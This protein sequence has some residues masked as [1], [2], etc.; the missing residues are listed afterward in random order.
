LG[1]ACSTG[2]FSITA[3][4]QPSTAAS[5]TVSGVKVD[6]SAFTVRTGNIYCVAT[7]GNDANSGKF[8]NCW[9]TIG[10]AAEG[11]GS[12]AAGD[13][14]Y[15]ENG[16][17]LSPGGGPYSDTL[18]IGAPG[19]AANPIA[20]IA[21]PGATV[22]IGTPTGD[23]RGI[24]ACNGLSGCSNGQDWV[25]AG[26]T[27][28]AISE[29]LQLNTVGFRLVANDVSCPNGN[30]Q[31]GCITGGPPSSFYYGNAVH[32]VA[33]N[34]ASSVTRLY[35]SI[36]LGDGAHAVDLG[37]NSITHNHGN[38]AIQIFTSTSGGSGDIYD[39]H[40][41]D[42]LIHDSRGIGI[43]MTSVA[44]QK[45]PLEAYNNLIYNA[46]TGP[47][48]ADGPASVYCFESTLGTGA[49]GTLQLYN[50]TFYNCGWTGGAASNAAAI[51]AFAPTNI[52][53]NLIYNP[54]P[55]MYFDSG[56]SGMTCANNLYFGS[57]AAPS[58]CAN[59]AVSADPKITSLSTFDFHLQ[60]GSPAIDKGVA[61]A[62]LILDL[63]GTSRPQGAAYDIG[64]YE[65]NQGSTPPPPPPP[66]TSACDLNS[67]NSVNVADVQVCVNQVLGVVPCT[68]A[69]L[70]G[71]G[72][73]TAVDVQRV[74][75][76]V[77]GQT[78][79]VGQ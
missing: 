14:I 41:H 30:D 17:V 39:I 61:I 56:S 68:N 76:S 23:Q 24:Y 70:Q 40:A 28:R 73:C 1:S 58:S 18:T 69:D 5:V 19:T 46:G 36:Y 16:V 51:A 59:G 34:S 35:H 55:L 49:S 79:V 29:G 67:D 37:W 6:N 4:G 25:F 45:G 50:N 10:H 26:L 78:C 52:R 3:N 13:I 57:G 65:F 77:L 72:L 33:A 66:T 12:V 75:N 15:V 20:L 38:R 7:S 21:Y 47:D 74:V 9:K 54:A 53:N 64:A 43:V 71:N 62:S 31:A 27:I 22:T 63:D 42:N 60:S 32:D 11:N 8:P 2:K 48:F 44:P